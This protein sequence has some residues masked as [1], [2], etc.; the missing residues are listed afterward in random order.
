MLCAGASLQMAAS[1]AHRHHRA[2]RSSLISLGSRGAGP[3]SSHTHL[4]RSRHV[5]PSLL[6]PM[7]VPPLRHHRASHRPSPHHAIT[8]HTAPKVSSRRA[9]PAG[10]PVQRPPPAG[11]SRG[12]PHAHRSRTRVT[13]PAEPTSLTLSQPR[14]AR[15]LI[16]A[17]PP[18]SASTSPLGG[19]GPCEEEEEARWVREADRLGMSTPPRAHTHTAHRTTTART[20]TPHHTASNRHTRRARRGLCTRGRDALASSRRVYH[21]AC[22]AIAL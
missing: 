15:T 4:P 9:C 7:L 18:R 20:H 5:S 13:G 19:L 17:R 1:T 8:P 16:I 22:V 6:V 10:R 2:R 11:L 12:H 14:S 3:H 21:Q